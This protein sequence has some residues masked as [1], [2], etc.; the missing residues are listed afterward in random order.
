[1][2]A[3]TPGTSRRDA[4]AAQGGGG[5]RARADNKNT[6]YIGIGG[7]ALVCVLI[8]AFM[9]SSGDSEHARPG[10]APTR[11]STAR[12]PRRRRPTSGERC[13]VGLDICDQALND[14]K[15]RRS[16]RATAL[17]SLANQLKAHHHPRRDRA[18]EGR[19]VQEEDR[20]GEGEP[21][22]HGPGQR[23]LR[24]MPPAPGRVRRHHVGQ[25]P[26]R[27]QGGPAPLGVDRGPGQL[28]EGLQRHQRADREDLSSATRRFG[29][30]IR[31]WQRFGETSPGPAA[32]LR[33]S[34]RRSGRSTS[35]PQAA[36]EKVVAEAGAGAEARSEARRGAGSAST[37]RDGPGASSTRRSRASSSSTRPWARVASL[38]TSNRRPAMKTR[39]NGDCC[40]TV[41]ALATLPRPRKRRT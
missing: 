27:H 36:A 28:A 40:A 12:S 1:M 30:A 15:S 33:A 26:S 38:T 29:E 19:R 5:T 34:S 17:Q 31:E 41:I 4:R 39:N 25:G 32:P 6:L 14:P 20:D 11:S 23:P 3:Q 9:L 8:L 2:N 24:R 7:G 37:A 10:S 35:R 16:S 21:D 18:D 13:R 22:R